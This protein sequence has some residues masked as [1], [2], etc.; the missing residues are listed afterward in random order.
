MKFPPGTPVFDPRDR[1][2]HVIAVPRRS[3]DEPIAGGNYVVVIFDVRR[4]PR[5]P[6]GFESKIYREDELRAARP[7][8]EGCKI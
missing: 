1:K 3:N 8:R 7:I 5:H 6:V 4:S 2:G